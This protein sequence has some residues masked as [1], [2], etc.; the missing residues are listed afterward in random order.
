MIPVAPGSDPIECTQDEEDL[1]TAYSI[2]REARH[3]L[4]QLDPSPALQADLKGAVRDFCFH[5]ESR[6]REPVKHSPARLPEPAAPPENPRRDVPQV[7]TNGAAVPRSPIPT[8][9]F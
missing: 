2:L 8:T 9:E 6:I 1:V 4:A 5:Y 3:Y 7:T